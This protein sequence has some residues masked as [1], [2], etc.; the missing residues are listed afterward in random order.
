MLFI[1]SLQF[2]PMPSIIHFHFFFY[3]C[4]ILIERTNTLPCPGTLLFSL[5]LTR[6][7]TLLNG[8]LVRRKST[9]LVLCPAA[10]APTTPRTTSH[11]FLPLRKTNLAQ[12][13]QFSEAKLGGPNY[14]KI[15]RLWIGSFGSLLTTMSSTSFIRYC[16]PP[17]CSIQGL[18]LTDA[19]GLMRIATL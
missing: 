3:I 8:G 12:D 2:L 17:I 7:G 14:L 11:H 15:N 5:S 18:A 6:V 1:G 16:G 10:G 9:Y 4:G 19:L 13:W